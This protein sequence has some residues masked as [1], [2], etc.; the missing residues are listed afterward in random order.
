MLKVVTFIL[1]VLASKAFGIYNTL[2]WS[3]CSTASQI[4]AIKIQKLSMLPMV[5]SM[6]L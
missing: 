4:P 1:T 5:S 6:K 2:E 3:S